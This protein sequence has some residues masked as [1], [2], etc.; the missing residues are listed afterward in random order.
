MTPPTC[1]YHRGA[2]MKLRPQPMPDQRYI[3]RNDRE[4]RALRRMW[5]CRV[6]DCHYIRIAPAARMV[7]P[8]CSKCGGYLDNADWITSR[9]CKRCKSG[10]RRNCSR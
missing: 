6:P 3:D 7:R 10:G 2:R 5:T 4:D 8:R 9:R 1:E